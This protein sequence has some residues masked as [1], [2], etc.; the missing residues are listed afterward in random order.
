MFVFSA[1]FWSFYRNNQFKSSGEL[2]FFNYSASIRTYIFHFIMWETETEHFHDFMIS[3]TRRDPS[4]WIWVYQVTFKIIRH[5]P[6]IWVYQISFKNMRHLPAHILLKNGGI[7]VST[8]FWFWDSG[9]LQ[10]WHSWEFCVLIFWKL[11]NFE[12]FQLWSF[13]HLKF[14]N[15]QNFEIF[16]FWECWSFLEFWK[17]CNLWNIEILKLWR[18]SIWFLEYWELWNFETLE[19]WNFEALE[20]WNFV[21]N[22]Q[23]NFCI[24]I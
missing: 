15:F 10:Y 18:L 19:I 2:F 11:E 14:L 7:W 5:N 8:V 1:I 12:A 17:F 23:T 13:E 3:D 16:E 20:F 4:L 21:T 22:S 24:L 9:T 6:G